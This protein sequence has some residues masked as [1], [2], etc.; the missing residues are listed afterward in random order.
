LSG[1]IECAYCGK[2]AYVHR[3]VRGRIQSH[4]VCSGYVASGR[5]VCEGIRIATA[6]L[7]DAVIDGIQKRLELVLDPHELRRRLS[8]LLAQAPAPADAAP[9]L[10]TRLV[11]TRKKIQRLVDV[12][13]SGSE[14]MPSVRAALVDLERERERLERELS[15]AQAR[16][17]P[18]G[19]HDR[20]ER[21]PC[22]SEVVPPS[23]P[24]EC[25]S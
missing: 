1:L 20:Q 12:L 24:A 4:Y 5:G 2:R 9:G 15:A 14:P 18:P 21:E 25:R 23:G 16:E 6:F 19:Y 3:Q 7:D 8:D 13:A 11:D 17:V 10:A 22:D